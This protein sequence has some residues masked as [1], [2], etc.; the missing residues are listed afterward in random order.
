[1]SKRK[2]QQPKRSRGP[3]AEK[4]G[5]DGKASRPDVLAVAAVCVALVLAVLFVFGQTLWH[6][7]VNYDDN[8]YVYANPRVAQGFAGGWL[9]WAFA[10]RCCNNWH[11]LTWFSHTLD[12]ELFGLSPWGHHATNVLL[13]AAAVVALFLVLRR[14]TDNVW[15]S[16]FAAAV[17]AI[18]PLHV[19]SVAWVAERKDLLSGLLFVLT[20]GAYVRY[21]QQGFSWVRYLAVVGCFA[22]GLMAKPM[23]VTLP[24]VLFLLDYWPLGR[25]SFGKPAIGASAEAACSRRRGFWLLIVEKLPLLLLSAASCA[26]TV[27]AQQGAIQ[28]LDYLPIATRM[29]NAVVSYVAYLGKMFYPV[30]LAVI[31]PHAGA[32]LPGWQVAGG[33]ALLAA[34]SAGVVLLRRKCPYLIVGWL[35]YLGMLV[36]VIGLVQVG[37]QSMADRYTYLPQIGLYVA[38]AW[39]VAQLTQSWRHGRLACGLAAAASLGALMIAA[40][41]QTSYWRDSE[42]LFNHALACTS[43]NAIAHC[44]LGIALVDKGENQK[45]IEQFEQALAV[46]S[47]P[48]PTM[49]LSNLADALTR[50]GHYKEAIERCEAAL[51]LD[52]G[53]ADAH[54]N[55]G[56]AL[57]LQGK[58]D[59]AIEHLR[60]S[61]RLRPGCAD[62]H[63]AYGVTLGQQHLDDEAIEQFEKAVEISPTWAD[64]HRNLGIAL[65]SRKQ[66]VAALEQFRIALG[67]AV[68][69]G[70]RA[71]A[72][73]LR[74]KVQACEARQ[75]PQ[76]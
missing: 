75:S 69:Q 16:G 52:P 4:L 23:L 26:V 54:Y 43:E 45:A 70:N 24:F 36:P 11:P 9:D 49:I 50:Q 67:L 13:Q 59:E 39:G 37:K 40:C 64:A 44:N 60:E 76:K 56:N 6:E 7:F 32:G 15:Q 73:D 2:E 68:A 5:R 55:L 1:M 62:A 47:N 14:M 19:E 51:K 28:S 41:E 53:Y 34:I 57:R 48:N 61:L 21:V 38:V 63:N 58:Y 20:I 46:K 30:D 22:L 17:F 29:A 33:L 12:A 74:A 10:S 8:V 42:T 25:M 35:W 71:L 65:L 31:Y 18:H 72:D 27:W 3:A 66:V